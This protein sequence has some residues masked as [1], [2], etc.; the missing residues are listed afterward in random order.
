MLV[1]KAFN[2]QLFNPLMLVVHKIVKQALKILQYL[3]KN[4]YGE[5]DYFS[6]LD[7]TGLMPL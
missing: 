6:A 4:F 7:I 3:L 5:F 1:G 2:K